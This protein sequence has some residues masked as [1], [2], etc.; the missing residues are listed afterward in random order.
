MC[1][2]ELI[3]LCWLLLTNIL[4]PNHTL[5][6]GEFQVWQQNSSNQVVV[7]TDHYGQFCP[8]HLWESHHSVF[9]IMK[10]KLC[11]QFNNILNL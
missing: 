8:S 1:K 3:D 7:S 2:N 11:A 9:C 10:D 5:P 6:L 4:K